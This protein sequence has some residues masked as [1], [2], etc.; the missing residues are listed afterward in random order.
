M[1]RYSGSK[2]LPLMAAPGS[3]CPERSNGAPFAA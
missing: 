2:R 3:C 1:R